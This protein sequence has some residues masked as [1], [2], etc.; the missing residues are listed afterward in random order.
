M[1]L[2]LALQ[3]GGGGTT[4]NASIALNGV[5]SLTVAAVKESRASVSFDGVGAAVFSAVNENLATVAFAGSGNLSA[6]AIV[7]GTQLAAV[8]LDGSG[9]LSVSAEVV[10]AAPAA[11]ALPTQ[12]PAGIVRDVRRR[13]YIM[14]DGRVFIATTEEVVAL[15]Q[16]YAVPKEALAQLTAPPSAARAPVEDL[17]KRDIRFVPAEDTL[18]GTFK[19]VLSERFSYRAPEEAYRQAEIIANRIRADEEALLLLI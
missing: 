8:A 15:L 6:A 13:R 4:H 9:D 2:L 5:G 14:P 12:V 3:G 11:D 17:Q 10:A 1:S 18:P 16:L 19:A 7:A